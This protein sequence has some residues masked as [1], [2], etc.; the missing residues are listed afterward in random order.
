MKTIRRF[1]HWCIDV[2]YAEGKPDRLLLAIFIVSQCLVLTNTLLHNPRWGYDAYYYWDYIEVFPDHL[3]TE[4][5]SQEFF[6]APLPFIIPAY[7]NV[8]CKAAA[9]ALDVYE[10]CD[11]IFGKVGQF[12]NLILS[13]LIFILMLKIADK[14]FPG[15]Q[16]FKAVLMAL[17]SILPV[18]YKTFAMLRGEPYVAFFSILTVYLMLQ[19]FERRDTLAWRDGLALGIA[20]GGLTLSRQ[21][22]FLT[23]P[24][25]FGMQ[26]VA[27]WIDR[28]YAWRLFKVLAVA[29]IVAFLISGWWYIHLF[30]SSGSFTAFN[31]EGAGGFAFSNQPVSFYWST[32]LRE[33]ALFKTATEGSF[34]NQL[35]PTLYSDMWGDYWGFFVYINKFSYLADIGLANQDAINPYLGRV[36]LVGI[37]PTAILVA[38]LIPGTRLALRGIAAR[39]QISLQGF[40]YTFISLLCISIFAGYL[41]FLISYPTYEFGNTIKATYILQMLHLITFFGA[42]L[43]EQL[44][45]KYRKVYPATLVILG[46]VLIHNLPAMVTRHLPITLLDLLN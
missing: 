7:V 17:F 2:F 18:H 28:G 33:W 36:N 1:W 21:W 20:V 13:I 26:L 30:L 24:A 10:E 8:L 3:P 11:F 16:R 44:S 22:G 37:L 42:L 39:N 29:G 38:G 34:T 25:L 19:Q 12:I 4:A 41:W 5:D 35:W 27:L 9:G 40:F 43:I 46:L 6:S 15:N 45:E 14:V 23:I 32:G 31:M